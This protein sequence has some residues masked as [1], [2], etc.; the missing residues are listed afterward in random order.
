MAQGPIR[1]ESVQNAIDQGKTVADAIMGESRPYNAVP[2]FWSD[3]YDAK[4]QIVGL[5]Q[6]YDDTVTLG[7]VGTGRFSVL[8]FRAGMLIGIDSVNKPADHIAGRKLFGVGKTVPL[9]AARAPGFDLRSQ[10]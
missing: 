9:A 6:D 2:W 5:T 7:D 1:L 4:L 8:Y 10:V 3:Q